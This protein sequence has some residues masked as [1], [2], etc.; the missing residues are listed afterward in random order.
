MYEVRK[1]EGQNNTSLRG[2]TLHGQTLINL[3][4]PPAPGS[5]TELPRSCLKILH[6]DR[7]HFVFVSKMSSGNPEPLPG[8]GLFP[9][10]QEI[11]CQNNP[12]YA[13]KNDW[14]IIG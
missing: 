13:L 6:E 4:H 3:S 8:K 12:L 9:K 2:A 10:K 14:P 5:Q 7:F 11:Y 1:T